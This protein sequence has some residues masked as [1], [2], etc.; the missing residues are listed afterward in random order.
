MFEGATKPNQK[1]Q[2]TFIQKQKAAFM[3]KIKYK[4]H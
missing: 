2:Q 3:T 1:K 4:W